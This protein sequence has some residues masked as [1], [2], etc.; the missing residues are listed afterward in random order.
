[1]RRVNSPTSDK[2]LVNSPSQLYVTAKR[3]NSYLRKRFLTD[4]EQMMYSRSK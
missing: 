2:K 1:M 4:Y 3:N